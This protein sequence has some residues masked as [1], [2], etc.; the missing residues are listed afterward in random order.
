METARP[1][2]DWEAYARG[3]RKELVAILE[4]E[5]LS[6]PEIIVFIVCTVLCIANFICELFS[7]TPPPIF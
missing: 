3:M 4:P 7:T 6:R 2:T 1:E 5:E